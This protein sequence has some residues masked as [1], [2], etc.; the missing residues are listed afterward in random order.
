MTRPVVMM[1]HAVG[2]MKL[3]NLTSGGALLM[4]LPVSYVLLKLGASPVTVFMVNVIPWF[5]ET[6]FD[7]LC[8]KKYI[9]LSP[10]G[11]L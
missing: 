8:L 11:I 3:V 5:L 6:F 7:L 1:I 2:K 9:G 4:I 10:L